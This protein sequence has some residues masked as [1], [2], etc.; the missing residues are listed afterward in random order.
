MLLSS[1][2]CSLLLAL[3]DSAADRI[4]EQQVEEKNN[5]GV[6][7]GGSEEVVLLPS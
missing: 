3:H 7:F 5:C 2:N 4:T 6:V 1:S